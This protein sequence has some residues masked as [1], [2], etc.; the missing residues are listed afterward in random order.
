MERESERGGK[1][2]VV[3]LGGNTKAFN[4][5]EREMNV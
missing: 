1:Y 4:A 5:R 3:V 2:T